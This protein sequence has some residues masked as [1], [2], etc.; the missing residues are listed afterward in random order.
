ML[1]Q[2]AES[3]GKGIKRRFPAQKDREES[4]ETEPDSFL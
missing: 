1:V 4:L 3:V 2:D